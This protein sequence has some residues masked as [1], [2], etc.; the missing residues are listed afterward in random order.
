MGV[1]L[2]PPLGEGVLLLRVAARPNNCPAPLES[3]RDDDLLVGRARFDSKCQ[4]SQLF[5]RSI[6]QLGIILAFQKR[7][8]YLSGYWIET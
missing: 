5:P 6:Y 4:F 7:T 1:G 2:T 8:A 3:P